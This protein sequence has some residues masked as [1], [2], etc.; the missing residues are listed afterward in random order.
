MLNDPGLT[1]SLKALR[2]NMEDITASS[3]IS[4]KTLCGARDT[5]KDCATG[6][7]DLEK[8]T[9]WQSIF[10]ANIQRVKEALRVLE[11]F[12]K[13][14]DEKSCE[15]FKTLRFKVYETEKKFCAKYLK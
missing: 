6:F 15:G 8:K 9:D 13:L 1:K 12:F 3:G 10:F 2:H 4:K 11:E 14:F 5:K 7:C